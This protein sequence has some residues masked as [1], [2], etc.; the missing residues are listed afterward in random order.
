MNGPTP[1]S[2]LAAATNPDGSQRFYAPYK[3]PACAALLCHLQQLQALV[4]VRGVDEE[5]LA[6]A[7]GTVRSQLAHFEYLEN[8]EKLAYIDLMRRRQRRDADEQI[9]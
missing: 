8:L 7:I 2:I 1:S 4:H 6:Q 5:N 9:Q 3:H